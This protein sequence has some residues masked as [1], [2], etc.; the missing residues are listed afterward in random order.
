MASAFDPNRWPI[1]TQ[2]VFQAAVEHARSNG[3]PPI[4]AEHLLAALLSQPEVSCFPCWTRP[5]CPPGR[6]ATV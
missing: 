2:E 1:K 4:T 5:V 6:P 3:N